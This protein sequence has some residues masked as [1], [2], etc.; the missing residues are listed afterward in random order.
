MFE[1]LA[2]Y[3]VDDGRLVHT[4]VVTLA[5]ASPVS[6]SAADRADAHGQRIVW[7]RGGT[8]REFGGAER[9]TIEGLRCFR[10]MGAHTTLLLT[11]PL[12]SKTGAFFA[13]HHSD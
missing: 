3:P 4:C 12:S 2:Q 9:V 6:R 5:D 1:L 7:F 8:M 11:E 13:A 10:E